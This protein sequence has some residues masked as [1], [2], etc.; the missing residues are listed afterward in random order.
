MASNKPAFSIWEVLILVG[1]LAAVISM[2]LGRGG[3]PGPSKTE[4]AQKDIQRISN[5]VRLHYYNTT[6]YP[7]QLAQLIQ[8][9]ADRPGWKGPY[10]DRANLKDPWGKP[11]GYRHPG[12]EQRAFDIYSTGPDGVLSDDDLTS[13]QQVP[14]TEQLAANR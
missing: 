12:G 4:Q 11:Y 1:F 10:L 14:G 2:V 7:D 3:E 5:A 6:E 9:P 13:W 8:K